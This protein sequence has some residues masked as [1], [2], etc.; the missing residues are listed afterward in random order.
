VTGVGFSGSH[1]ALIPAALL[2]SIFPLAVLPRLDVDSVRLDV[3]SA[4]LSLLAILGDCDCCAL[5]D[6]ALHRS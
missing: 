2:L 6:P 4:V 1:I 5:G 3:D